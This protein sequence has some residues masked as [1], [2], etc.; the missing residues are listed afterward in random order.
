MECPSFSSNGVG[1]DPNQG[2]GYS[3][4]WSGTSL[5]PF[6]T[7]VIFKNALLPQNNGKKGDEHT[8]SP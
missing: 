6:K 5:P 2:E 1:Y 4:A 7:I 8:K 3:T